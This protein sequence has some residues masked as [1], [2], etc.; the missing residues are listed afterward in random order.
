MMIKKIIQ[1]DKYMY[2]ADVEIDKDNHRVFSVSISSFLGDTLYSIDTREVIISSELGKAF[3]NPKDA[4]T[5]VFNRYI[6]KQRNN[7]SIS[8][9]IDEFNEWDGHL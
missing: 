1:T 4:V 6:E 5:F 8:E 3:D 9:K 2:M 7:R